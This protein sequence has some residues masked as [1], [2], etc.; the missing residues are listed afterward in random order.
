[1]FN[2]APAILIT[3][4]NKGYR[5]NMFDI[6]SLRSL[7]SGLKL[8]MLYWSGSA[9]QNKDACCRQNYNFVLTVSFS[10]TKLLNTKVN[11][12]FVSYAE[13]Q[14]YTLDFGKS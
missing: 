5:G 13:K 7:E 8:K 2:Y 9:S 3:H 14:G 10:P 11:K 1:M 12:I 6:F 4:A